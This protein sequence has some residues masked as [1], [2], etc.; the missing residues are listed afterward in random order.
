L[1]REQAPD[2]GATLAGVYIDDNTINIFWSGDVRVYIKD[3]NTDFR[4]VTKDHTLAQIM[5]DSRILIK[6]SEID[7][8]KNTVTRGLGSEG[9]S[10]LPE[11]TSLDTRSDM[12]G[13]ICSDG[14]HNLFDDDEIFLMLDQFEND[15]F[16]TSLKNRVSLNSRDN[17]SVIMFHFYSTRNIH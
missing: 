10:A 16:V 14:F 4:F 8:L 2:A 6:P 12:M 17:A 13:M 1:I 11:I 3:V 15:S 5:R 9:D 7:R